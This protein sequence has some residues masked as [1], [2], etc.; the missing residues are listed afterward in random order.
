MKMTQFNRNTKR[1]EY[2]KIRIF[3]IHHEWS[4]NDIMQ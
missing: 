2:E 1:K 3:I 4:F